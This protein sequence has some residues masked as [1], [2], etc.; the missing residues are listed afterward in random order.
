MQHILKTIWKSRHWYFSINIDT[1]K[2]KKT[3]ILIKQKF[4]TNTILVLIYLTPVSLFYNY[5]FLYDLF[6]IHPEA[7]IGVL[8]KKVV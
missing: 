2:T 8:E 4:L 5:S 3:K 1:A 7:S 6:F